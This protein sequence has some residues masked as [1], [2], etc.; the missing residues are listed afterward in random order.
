M[1]VVVGWLGA[2]LTLIVG[3]IFEVDV[4]PALMSTVRNQ[5]LILG[6]LLVVGSGLMIAAGFR[7]LEVSTTWR[8]ELL[9]LPILIAGWIL[10]TISIA[11]P[12]QW[13]QVT[14]AAFPIVVG[15]SFVSA[16]AVRLRDVIFTIKRTRRN[17]A[18]LPPE[19]RGDA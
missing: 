11:F 16:C 7:W 14:P 6:L 3:R 10:Y 4:N 15:I 13:D 8:L 19:V 18:A 5:Q 2:G 1:I 17:V 9:G 12:P